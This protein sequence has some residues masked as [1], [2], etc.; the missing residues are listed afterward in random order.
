MLT[1]R[2]ECISRFAGAYGRLCSLVAG[3]LRDL[4]PQDT[5]LAASRGEGN[6]PHPAYCEMRRQRAQ[7][8]SIIT[9]ALNIG[10]TD[11]EL[12][13]AA[14]RSRTAIEQEFMLR[15]PRM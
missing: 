12:V 13:D 1:D 14:R 15:I 10:V 9:I 5:V 8:N 2:D 3:A 6:E 11:Q 4:R 7:L